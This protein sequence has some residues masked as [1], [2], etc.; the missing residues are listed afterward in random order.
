MASPS[1]L[2]PPGGGP[3]YILSDGMIGLEFLNLALCKHYQLEIHCDL[4]SW[5]I[6]EVQDDY[7]QFGG[8]VLDQGINRF[9]L[10]NGEGGLN[11]VYGR[12]LLEMWKQ[13]V[14]EGDQEA[15]TGQV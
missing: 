3:R 8:A 7:Q 11:S 9:L 5:G 13:G 2:L 4:D 6:N 15:A 1:S 14:F 10:R 12:E